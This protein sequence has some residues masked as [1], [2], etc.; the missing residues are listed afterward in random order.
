[1][2]R[3]SNL[4]ETVEVEVQERELAFVQPDTLPYPVPDQETRVEDGDLRFL[5]RVELAVDVDENAIVALVR[6][7]LMRSPGQPSPLHATPR[8]SR[9]RRPSNTRRSGPARSSRQRPQARLQIGPLS[10]RRNVRPSRQ[11]HAPTV[12]KC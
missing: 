11:R 7:R 12:L 5:P 4:E 9:P 10:Q 8:A 2:Y 3:L 1:M 6:Q